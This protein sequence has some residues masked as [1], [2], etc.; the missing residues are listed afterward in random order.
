MADYGTSKNEIN[1]LVVDDD[2]V[3]SEAV[4]RVLGKTT[5]NFTITT[6]AD[7]LEGLQILRGEHPAKEIRPPLLVLLDLN[8]PRMDGL[9]FLDHL[10][11]DPE[12]HKTVVF[13]F[14]TSNLDLDRE[15]SYAKHI[16]GYIVKSDVGPQYTKLAELFTSYG[17]SITL[18]QY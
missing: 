16:A 9:D 1:I 12:L 17:K 7:G 5:L 11:A 8:M 10:R 18:P 4:L 15:A 13:V 3:S 14:T 2:D 6:A